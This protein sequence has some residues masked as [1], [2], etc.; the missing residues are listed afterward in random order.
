[1]TFRHFPYLS[2]I[3]ILRLHTMEYSFSF[4]TYPLTEQCRWHQ[5]KYSSDHLYLEIHKDSS[6]HNEVTVHSDPDLFISLCL[7]KA[8]TEDLHDVS[9]SW[10]VKKSTESVKIIETALFKVRLTHPKLRLSLH[11]TLQKQ[12]LKSQHL[13]F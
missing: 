10:L 9:G 12:K 8:Q 2:I 7:T 13:K 6:I 11:T 1:M 3:V 5:N 4:V